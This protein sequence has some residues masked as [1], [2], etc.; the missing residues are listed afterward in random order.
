ME[1]MR[2]D[3]THPG[4]GCASDCGRETLLDGI[5]Q[6]LAVLPLRLL[7]AML[8]EKPA[9]EERREEGRDAEP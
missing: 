9:I 5:V 8:G 7:L 1:A 6:K 2:R 4:P 3:E